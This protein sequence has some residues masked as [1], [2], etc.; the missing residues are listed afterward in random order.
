MHWW[1]GGHPL[2]D[3]VQPDFLQGALYF[4]YPPLTALLL[5]PFAAI[6][7]GA[8]VVIFT[9]LTALAVLVTTW[10]LVAPIAER[11]GWPRWLALGVAIPLAFAVESTRETITFGQINMLLVVL[12]LA[13]LLLAVPRGSRWSGVGVG[14]AAAIKLYPGIFIVY[15]L[16]SRRWRAAAT[17]SA[18]AAGVT[19]LVG[20]VAPGDSW[21]F[22]THELWSTDRVGRRPDYTGNQSLFGML[23]RFTVPDQPGRPLWLGLV[24]VVA[25]FGLW[26]AVR[27]ARAGDELAGLTLTGLVGSLASP[28]TWPHHVY[29]FIPA[30]VVLADAGLGPPGAGPGP[31]GVGPGGAR[32]AD[33]RRHRGWLLF[34]LLVYAG[35]VYGVVSFHDWGIGLDRTA[36]PASF[37]LR[38]LYVVL[39]LVLLVGLPAR[40]RAALD[41]RPAGAGP[42]GGP[43]GSTPVGGTAGSA[44]ADGEGTADS[45]PGTGPD[46]RAVLRTD[47]PR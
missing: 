43:A 45:A 35:S 36:D 4:T 26:R 6:P 22:W 18:T 37:L 13:D 20:A 39:A 34:A 40:R 32:S 14:L 41:A 9:I 3:Y 17:A 28:I 44:T 10:W 16:A 11:R 29:W 27:A 47:R 31:P 24:L 21:R 15:L 5:R 23:S 42:P 8:T 2:Y 25:A 46:A 33:R 7:L 12:V 19:L 38:N 30:V 1:S